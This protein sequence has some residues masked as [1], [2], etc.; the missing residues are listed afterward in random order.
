LRLRVPPNGHAQPVW[1]LRVAVQMATVAWFAVALL[2][3]L[4]GLVGAVLPLLPGLP[5]VLAGV[6]LYALTTGLGAGVG[7]GHLVVYTLIGGVTIILSSLANLLGVRAAGGSRAGVLGAMVGLLVG[8]F[9]GG[10]IGLIIGPFVGAVAF[11]LLAGQA[12][13]RAVRS[14]L[15][16]AAGL[17]VGRLAELSVSVGLIASFFFSVLAAGVLAR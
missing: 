9:L 14:G 17:L 8:L 13:R 7:L 15:G 6:Y 5:L 1:L 16:A 2:L 3:M 10:P 4:A 12:G 11:E